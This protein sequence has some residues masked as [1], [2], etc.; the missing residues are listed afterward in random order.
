M[1]HG[2]QFFDMCIL[3]SM[4]SVRRSG[5]ISLGNSKVS[6]VKQFLFCVT[7]EIFKILMCRAPS[8][9]F[10]KPGHLKV[11]DF[12]FCPGTLDVGKLLF[13]GGGGGLLLHM[14]VPRL[15]VEL[16]L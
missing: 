6:K 7:S 4:Y 15:G 14:E 13:L 12:L 10:G 2:V 16:E 11:L 9:E 3:C 5:Q 8:Q 1:F